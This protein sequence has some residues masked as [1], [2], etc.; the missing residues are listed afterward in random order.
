MLQKPLVEGLVRRIVRAKRGDPTLGPLTNLPGTWQNAATGWNMIALPVKNGIAPNNFRLLLNQFDETLVFTDLDSPVPNRGRPEDQFGAALQYIQSV[1]Q[2]VAV[3]SIG[4]TISPIGAAAIHHEPGFFINFTE[5]LTHGDGHLLDLVR[6]GS[7]PH[8]DALNA[9]GFSD[10]FSNVGA[11]DIS[12]QAIG[13][14]S[15]LPIGAGPRDLANPYLAPY[16]KFQGPANS[17]KGNVTVPGFPGFDPNVPLNLL[18]FAPAGATPP[19]F[20]SVTRLI[21]D[22]NLGGGIVNTPFV[23]TQ[24]NSAQMRFVMWIEEFEDSTAAAPHFQM[25]YAQRVLLEFFPSLDDPHHKI[26][27]PHISINTLSFVPGSAAS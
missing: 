13:D 25:Q 7:I 3:D 14:F 23:V 1:N 12:P 15:S 8:G 19:K 17:F 20:K 5:P 21:L 10:S 9:L 16:K 22:T 26:A 27:W 6:L 4:S 11:P 24:A 18:I 2:L